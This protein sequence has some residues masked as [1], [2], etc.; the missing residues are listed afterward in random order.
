MGAGGRTAFVMVLSRE[1]RAGEFVRICLQWM[2]GRR[3]N[4]QPHGGVSVVRRRRQSTTGDALR[5]D[6]PMMHRD[7]PVRVTP[8]HIC[9]HEI[10]V[11]T[12]QKFSGC[13]LFPILPPIGPPLLVPWY[14]ANS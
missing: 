7:R 2:V 5:T 14:D 9:A 8:W 4:P 3:S 6:S 12:C 10:L 11:S 1:F 13:A